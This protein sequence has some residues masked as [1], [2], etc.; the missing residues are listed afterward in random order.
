MQITALQKQ[1]VVM[2]ALAL[3][4]SIAL[5]AASPWVTQEHIEV[6]LLSDKNAINNKEPFLLG[7]ELKPEAGWHV[8]WQNPGDSG[9]PPAI[10]F[11]TDAIKT[12]EVLWPF[13]HRIPYGPLLNYG[14]EHV[15][16]PV[17]ASLKTTTEATTQHA[18]TSVT[19]LAKTSWLVCKEFCIPGK[20]SLSLELPVR[21]ET[22]VS[23]YADSIQKYLNKVPKKLSVIGG[24]ALASMQSVT[25]TVYASAP[26]FKNVKHLEFFP[27]NEQLVEAASMPQLKWKNNFLE[28]TQKR[29]SDFSS[30][31]PEISGVLVVDHAQAWQ[32]SLKAN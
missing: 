9:M 17:E 18:E 19:I 11:Q 8:Y 30:M 13:P 26:I 15:I 20:A 29:S 27:I 22:L 3:A 25:F 16:L 10:S 14:Y 7:W 1:L 31:P 6:R 23:Q 4:P 12:G 28:I 24:E 2:A 5:G 32:F 21:Q